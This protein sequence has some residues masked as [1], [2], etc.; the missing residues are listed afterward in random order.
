MKMELQDLREDFKC[1]ICHEYFMEGDDMMST[2]CKH[3]FHAMCLRSWFTGR[4][5][6][7]TGG[8]S[9]AVNKC[10]CCQ[11]EVYRKM[12]PEEDPHNV[13]MAEMEGEGGDGGGGG[14]GGWDDEGGG[15]WEDGGGGGDWE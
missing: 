11:Q 6:S 15:G 12:K 1:L 3:D 7:T 14:E 8:F 5:E 4:T 10:P 13:M 2:P 9:E